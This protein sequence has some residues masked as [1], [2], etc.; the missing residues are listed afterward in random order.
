MI[1][2][3]VKLASVKGKQFILLFSSFIDFVSTGSLFVQPV[4]A[5]NFSFTY[6]LLCRIIL[7]FSLLSH[8]L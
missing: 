3:D 5:L 4:F 7:N 6:Y 1:A 2:T 8:L